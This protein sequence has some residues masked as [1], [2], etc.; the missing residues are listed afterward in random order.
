VKQKYIRIEYITRVGF[1]LG[2]NL[3]F[4]NLEN[5]TKKIYNLIGGEVKRI[6]I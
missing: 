1:T 4:E 6:C 3:Q 2:L 5:Y